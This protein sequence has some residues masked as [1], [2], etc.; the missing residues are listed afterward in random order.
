MREWELKDHIMA[1]S[2]DT[3]S[4][5]TGAHNGAVIRLE[6]QLGH[7]CLWSAC[8]RHIHEVHMKHASTCVFGPTSGPSDLLFKRLQNS[9]SETVDNLDYSNLSRFDQEKASETFLEDAS[10]DVQNF[11]KMALAT[12]TFPRED[13]Q[14]LVQLILVWFKGAEAVPGLK[15]QYP[16][17]FHHARFMSKAIYILKLD[18]LDHQLNIL[19]DEEKEQVSRLALFI[20]Y[21]YGVMFLSSPRPEA[22]PWSTLLSFEQMVNFTEVDL[23]IGF[24]VCDSMRN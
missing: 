7:A 1:F 23:A 6:R 4:S 12:G 3:T 5:N 19:T 24:T 8:Q 9:W 18:I 2:F 14:E 11:C 21:F 22:A 15:F 17:A 10:C 13:Y 20:S 16:E